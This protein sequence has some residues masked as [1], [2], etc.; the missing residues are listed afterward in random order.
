MHRRL[1]EMASSPMLTLVGLAAAMIL[2][3]AGTMAQVHLDTQIVQERYFQSIFVWWSS[4]SH[5]FKMPVFPGGHLIGAVLLMNLIAVHLVRFR[6]TWRHLGI[7]LTHAGLVI[8]LIGGFF[9]D[10]LSVESDMRLTEGE[11]KN[12]SENFQKMEL[13]ISHKIPN[14]QEQVTA[15]PMSRL[16]PG[17]AIQHAS[18]PFGLQIRQVYM[19]SR[20]QNIDETDTRAVPAANHGAGTRVA[21]SEAPESS[22]PGDQHARATASIVIEIV[23][24]PSDPKTA[25][26]G[27]WLVS[28]AIGTPQTIIYANQVWSIAMRPVRYYKPYSITLQKFTHER[29]PGTEIAKNFASRL[30][31]IDPERNEHRDVLIYM[32]HPLRYR[33]ETFYQ[34]GFDQDD[35]TTILQVVRNPSFMAP[36]IACII[37]SIG[38]LIQFAMHL[39]GMK[40]KD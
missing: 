27:T 21:V 26:L 37:V 40:M 36:Y 4:S 33:G 20:L 16:R 6:W 38:L 25:S 3:F 12:Y 35:K 30:T 29:Y 10:L 2:V 22:G 31:L 23:P 24:M 15:I 5:G 14:D 28:E 32:N 19:R 34:A 17:Q 39:T 13:I 1:L 7:Q 11:T 9:T 18:L 8:L